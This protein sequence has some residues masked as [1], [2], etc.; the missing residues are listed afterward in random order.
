MQNKSQ[1]K[2]QFDFSEILAI[3]WRRK[4][5]IAIPL[6]LVTAVT[7]AG[8]YLITPMYESSVIIS[9]GD[10]VKLTLDIRRLIGDAGQGYRS[11]RDRQN[12]LRALQ[13]EI[14]S[15]PFIAELE[16]HPQHPE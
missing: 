5:L 8:S 10:Q 15:S 4:W 3:V 11:E 16:I 13:N 1:N 7:M 9:V 14:T 2:E 6:I 12:E